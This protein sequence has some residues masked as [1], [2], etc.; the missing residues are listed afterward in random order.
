[1]ATSI[2]TETRQYLTFKLDKE[3][4]AMDVGQMREILEF[5]SVTKIPQTP[6][7]VKG[8]INLRGKVVPVVDMRLKFGL[9]QTEK[10]VNTCIIVVEISFIEELIIIGALVDAVQ[11]VVELEP[12]Q[13]EPAPKMGSR[14]KSDFIKGM[15]KLDD[16]FI[17]IL[18]VDKVFSVEELNLLQEQEA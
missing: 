11:E 8:V 7:F 1:M 10:T 18:D 13:I 3:L 6:P 2:I 14:L 12:S 17:I 4:Y 9:T 5:N 15:G 16:N